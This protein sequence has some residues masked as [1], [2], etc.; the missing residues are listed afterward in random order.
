MASRFLVQCGRA[1]VTMGVDCMGDT[2]YT[3]ESVDSA[4]QDAPSGA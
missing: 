4:P 3:V 1:D 2:A